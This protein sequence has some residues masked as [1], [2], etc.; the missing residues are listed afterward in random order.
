MYIPSSPSPPAALLW[1]I[2]NKREVQVC[3]A[4]PVPGP[5]L[6][7]EYMNRNTYE[8]Y[9]EHTEWQRPLSGIHSLMTEKLAQAGEGEGC[10]P[11][12]VHYTLFTI[13]YKVA[14]YATAGRADILPLFH[15]YPYALCG[16]SLHPVSDAKLKLSV[17][18]Y[19]RQI[20]SLYRYSTIE[21]A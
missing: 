5:Y 16:L 21:N 20:P 3:A 13:T 14:M 8:S 1:P 11:T 18:T 2:F 19:A 4:M 17:H 9:R 6:T 10:T 7:Q 12:S 15:I